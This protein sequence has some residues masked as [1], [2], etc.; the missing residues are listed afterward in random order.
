MEVLLKRQ[1]M[2]GTESGG[3]SFCAEEHLHYQWEKVKEFTGTGAATQNKTRLI[4]PDEGKMTGAL[5]LSLFVFHIKLFFPGLEIRR[6]D[7]KF[8]E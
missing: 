8:G 1:Q 5:Y 2:T 6:V 7:V 3:V 4:I